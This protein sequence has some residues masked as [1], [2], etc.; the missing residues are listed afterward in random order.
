MAFYIS[1]QGH[2]CV[3]NPPLEIVLRRGR[4]RALF[5][6]VLHCVHLAGESANGA[7]PEIAVQTM[8]HIAR[9]AE[10]GVNF[11]QVSGAGGWGWAGAWLPRGPGDCNFDQPC[12]SPTGKVWA[13]GDARYWP[14]CGW[15]CSSTA[16]C[17][18]QGKAA[19]V[20]GAH[21]HAGLLT[22]RPCYSISLC[23]WPAFVVAVVIHRRTTTSAALRPS[24]WGPLRVS[25]APSPRTQSTSAQVRHDALLWPA[26]QSCL[27][28]RSFA[29]RRTL[30]AHNHGTTSPTLSLFH[31]WRPSLLYL[32]I[33]P[34]PS[35][36]PLSS[37]TL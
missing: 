17:S 27:Q 26:E 36:V 31:H 25:A 33:R 22:R 6:C 19:C 8:A 35:L 2:G 34:G 3:N 5:A 13:L 16:V 37:H 30:C 14:R 29:R 28:P 7:Y 24:L 1:V 21:G 10:I 32:S 20:S 15:L 23:T 18:A 11:Y 9:S 12:H 4:S